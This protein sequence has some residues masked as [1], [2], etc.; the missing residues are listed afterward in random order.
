M[1]GVTAQ[2]LPCA[3]KCKH[4]GGVVRIGVAAQGASSPSFSHCHNCDSFGA[5]PA[6]NLLGQGHPDLHQDD[7]GGQQVS[8]PARLAGVYLPFT[9][10]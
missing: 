1:G 5:G 3:L 8:Q 10:K 4:E 7:P 9:S 2:H 6:R